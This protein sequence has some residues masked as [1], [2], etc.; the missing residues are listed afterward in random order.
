[1]YVCACM[2]IHTHV[3]LCVYICTVRQRE[4]EIHTSIEEHTSIGKL[5]AEEN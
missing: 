2:C 5:T 1:M 3:C 4:S